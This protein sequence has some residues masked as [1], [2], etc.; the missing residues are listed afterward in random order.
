M[1]YADAVREALVDLMATNREFMDAITLG[2][3]QR[4]RLLARTDI[5]NN[6]LREVLNNPQSE[7]RL[8]PRAFRQQLFEDDP[9]C[10]LCS[11][12]IMSVDDAAGDHTVPYSFGG[13]TSVANGRLAHR[14]CNAA[15]GNRTTPAT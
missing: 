12:Q 2:T 6:R 13:S 8:F 11:Q 14:Y 3:S 4:S 10:S 1:P 7:P 5:W 9:T 15:R